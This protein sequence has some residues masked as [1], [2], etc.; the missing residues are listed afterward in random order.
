MGELV[1][2]EGGRRG[3]WGVMLSIHVVGDHGENTVAQRR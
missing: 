2:S 3:L 1:A